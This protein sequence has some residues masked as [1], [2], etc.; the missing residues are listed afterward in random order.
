M[1]RPAPWPPPTPARPASRW[2][3]PHAGDS[4]DHRELVRGVVERAGHRGV[5][6]GDGLAALGLARQVRPDSIVP[7]L[8]MPGLDGYE[9]ARQ[10]R[11]EPRTRPI[12]IAFYTAHYL[13][14]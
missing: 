10:L 12:P 2:R 3:W 5:G 14:N 4:R 13:E 6:G 7:D 11:D 8:L 1:R 9:L